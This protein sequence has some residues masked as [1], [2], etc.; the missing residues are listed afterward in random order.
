MEAAIKVSEQKEGLGVVIRNS[1]GSV[2][3]VA[4][5][6]VPYQG[7]VAC[8]EGEAA[9]FR[10]QAAQQVDCVPMIIESYSKEV[11]D[12]SLNIKESKTEITWIIA[13]IQTKLKIQSQA[14]IQFAP[15]VCNV[16]AHS[17]A[18][19]ALAAENH[20]IWLENFPI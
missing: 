2:V 13:E 20:C 9:L 16:I 7:N 1:S 8:M 12:L 14:S 18:K 6:N 10:I 15:R 19:K 4:I 3:T 11:V 17:I 5:Q